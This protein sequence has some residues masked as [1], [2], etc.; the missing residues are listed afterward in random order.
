MKKF[1]FSFLIFCSFFLTGFYFSSL[2]IFQLIGIEYPTQ[3]NFYIHSI[4]AMAHR[5]QDPPVFLESLYDV[6]KNLI[7][8]KEDFLEANLDEMKIRIYNDGSLVEEVPI[9]RKGNPERWGGTPLGIYQV[10]SKYK[11]AYSALADSF[12]PWSLHLYGKYYIHGDNYY[13]GKGIDTMP[14]TGGCLRLSDNNAKTVFN[15]VEVGLPILATNQ[16]LENDDYEYPSKKIKRFPQLTAQSYLVADLDSGFVFAGKDYQKQLPIASITKLITATVIAEIIDLRRIVLIDSE[17]LEPPQDTEGLVA[18]KNFRAF[19]LFYPLLIES[20]NDAAEALG[21]FLSKEKTVK[22]MNEKTKAI[23]MKDTE[24]VDLSGLDSRNISTCQDLFYLT[25]YILNV[26]P[27]FLD[28]SRGE[29]VWTF[30]LPVNFENLENKNIFYD[31]PSFLG[32]KTGFIQASQSTGLFIFQFPLEDGSER[33]V[34]IILLGSPAVNGF[35][36]NLEKD[37][38]KVLDWLGENYFGKQQSSL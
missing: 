35:P 5:K 29:E 16:G 2:F 12:M 36:V 7:L 28:I 31:K 26:R 10:L 21:S 14:I 32:G 4:K 9:F 15:S 8:E 1:L 18:G 22:L 20:S 11:L 38:E 3:E 37:V 13:V 27:M 30:N 19:E 34:A 24:L 6:R 33:R 23:L 25:R 17:M